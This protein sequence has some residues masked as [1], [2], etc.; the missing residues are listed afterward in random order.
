VSR[1][2]IECSPHRE[3]GDEKQRTAA[4]W[5]PEPPLFIAAK[6]KNTRPVLFRLRKRRRRDH[7][8]E[9]NP[10][11]ETSTLIA[12]D[13]KISREKLTHVPTPPATPTHQ[14]IP[15]H[16]IVEALVP[17]LSPDRRGSE[18]I[19]RLQR[20]LKMFGVFDLEPLLIPGCRFAFNRPYRQCTRAEQPCLT[21]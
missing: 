21:P 8:K 10:V 5:N 20:R 18:G 4:V 7:K 11:P 19:H 3:E 12:Y 6:T 16:Q 13:G 15:H 2:D 9:K 17:Q 14:T 1:T